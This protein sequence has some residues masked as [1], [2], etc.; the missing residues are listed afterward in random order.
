MKSFEELQKEYTGDGE[1]SY[2]I[3]TV[4]VD[5]EL[6][7]YQ[8]AM[9]EKNRPDQL[10]PMSIHRVND[11]WKLSYDITSRIPMHRIL[12]RKPV[13]HHE[14][15]FIIGQFA[16][17]VHDLKDYLLDL[18]SVVLDSAY[19]F[20]DPAA[21]TLFFMYLP[22]K[23]PENEPERI[24]CFLRKLITEE[25]HLTDD[26]SGT[27]LKKL[28]EALKSEAFTSELLYRCLNSGDKPVP[29]KDDKSNSNYSFMVKGEEDP[30]GAA[31]DEALK[32]DNHKRLRP[33]KLPSAQ[34][35][36]TVHHSREQRS[37]P[38]PRSGRESRPAQKS[39]G[40]KSDKTRQHT[41]SNQAP[42]GIFQRYPKSSW[43][44]AGG[45][46]LL[47]LGFLIMVIASSGKNPNNTVN[48]LLGFLL[49][50]GAGNY[51][52]ITRLFTKDKR[53][54]SQEIAA[55]AVTP[56]VKRFVNQEM[57]EDIILPKN[58]AI[59][60]W[61][62]REKDMMLSGL[63]EFEK[64]AKSETIASGASFGDITQDEPQSAVFGKDDNTTP[65]QSAPQKVVD[66]TPT[67]QSISIPGVNLSAPTADTLLQNPIIS[68]KTMVL[69]KASQTTPYLISIAR[70]HEKI[71]INKD[72]LLIGRLI[73]SVDY[74]IPNRAVGKIHAELKKIGDH[75]Y[76]TDLNSVNGTYVNDER[77]VCNTDVQLKNG[78]K[79]MLANETFTFHG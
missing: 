10:L 76:I 29:V 53:I 48:N 16:A 74:V 61:E 30:F 60:Q 52:L 72:T 23:T 59:R 68:D 25:L 57:D 20:C 11:D 17:L 78:D 31:D 2:L 34:T 50:A 62:H 8:I 40:D 51:F 15:E 7:Q 64:P 4:P 32:A 6:K 54:S 67:A 26:I 12:E 75:Y 37:I 22:M 36:D 18:P 19:I 69:S 13:K 49:I 63:S 66:F 35:Y 39:A 45:V 73:D 56:P 33:E 65:N 27:L 24:Q 43:M 71:L 77:L 38:I 1:K 79:I 5:C 28:L 55:T 42:G 70:P 44:I 3:L 58:H 14:F 47:L 41:E 9:L 21:F 46:N